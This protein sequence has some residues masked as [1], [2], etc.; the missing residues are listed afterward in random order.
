MIAGGTQIPLPALA[1]PGE[2][3]RSTWGA[4]SGTPEARARMAAVRAKGAETRR[5]RRAA[6]A[7]VFMD[8]EHWV[9]L[10]RARGVR[11]PAPG[12]PITPAAMERWLRRLG[13]T[14]RQY[15]DWTG[16]RTLAQFGA[17][18]PGWTLRAWVGLLLEEQP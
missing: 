6:P 14:T 13:M 8:E 10:A 3:P 5:A 11:L 18:N 7:I 15:L 16:A 17:A 12:V 9:E 4:V 2:A 1:S